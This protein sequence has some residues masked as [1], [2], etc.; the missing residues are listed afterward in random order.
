MNNW[1]TDFYEKD[2]FIYFYPRM[3]KLGYEGLLGPPK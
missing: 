1:C 2:G 3:L